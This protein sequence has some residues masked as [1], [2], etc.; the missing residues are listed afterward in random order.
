[1]KRI[2]KSSKTIKQGARANRLPVSVSGLITL[3]TDFGTQDYFVGAM[4]GVILSINPDAVTVDITHDIPPQDIE[5]AAFTLL[6][7]YRSFPAGTIHVAVV[8]PGV[9]S[10]RRP[11]IVVA[12]K[13][14]FIGPDN[15]IFSYVVD[16]EPHHAVFHITAEKY[17]R[18][19][20]SSTFHGRDVFAPV[21][22]SLSTGVSIHAFGPSI[23]DE[24]RL[25]PL[26]PGTDRDGRIAARIIHVD[27]FGNLVTNIDRSCLNGKNPVSLILNGKKI[28]R[29]HE[30]YGEAGDD[31]KP[32]AIWGSAGFLEISSRN[33]S[34]SKL[35]GAKRG[36][37]VLL[38]L[39]D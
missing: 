7:G 1:M 30:F 31:R 6:A 4:K 19:P 23:T 26:K 21:A 39:K 37:P 27:H 13:H 8:D 28:E 17:F 5:A 35:L 34:A 24:I 9:G 20:Q 12:D 16:N 33:R 11:I 29:F 18:K 36:D 14:F 38:M 22:A 32:F 25:K 10:S 3:L 15:G 2:S